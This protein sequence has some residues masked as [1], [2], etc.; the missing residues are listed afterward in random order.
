MTFIDQNKY[1]ICLSMDR[2]IFV[3]H[4]RPPAEM[5]YKSDI[6]LRDLL[7]G[8]K[9]R[10]KTTIVPDNWK[11]IIEDTTITVELTLREYV[12]RYGNRWI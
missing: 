8:H 3:T 11:V 7:Y 5:F 12:Q 10:L 6:S 1:T 9:R 2:I 4:H